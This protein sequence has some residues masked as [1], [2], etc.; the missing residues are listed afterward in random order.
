MILPYIK[1]RYFHAVKEKS[2]WEY[3]TFW[4]VFIN[5]KLLSEVLEIMIGQKPCW[6]AAAVVIKLFGNLFLNRKSSSY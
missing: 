1:E 5:L 6:K 2:F 3:F 4:I